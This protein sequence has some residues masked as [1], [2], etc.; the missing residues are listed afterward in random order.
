MAA[1]FD[2]FIIHKDALY[3]AQAAQAAFNV[4]DCIEA[5]LSKFIEN[6]DIARINSL[7]KGRPLQIGLSTF[8]CLQICLEMSKQTKG[9][10]DI[11]YGYSHKGGDLLKLNE[12][13][14]TIE[15]LEDGIQIDLGAIGKG[16]AADKIGQLLGDWGIN[17]AL[18]SAGQST[19]LP[20]G[21][22]PDLPGWPLS[23]SNPAD[24]RRLL[25][26]VHLADFA[27]SASGLQKGPHI[28]NPRSGK[29]VRGKLAAWSTAKTA[30][31]ADALST[32]FM[33]MPVNKIRDFCKAHPDTSA[34]LI[35]SGRK[36]EPVRFGQWKNT[37]FNY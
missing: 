30:A 17:T 9:A 33:V 16:Y 32:A 7:G 37:E 5:N 31:A 18:I 10:F 19:I 29:P 15:L 11:T 34:L 26:K 12:S 25:A 22:P 24:Y 21:T 2:I 6:S 3:A 14:H 36:K 20:I 28:I 35:P 13:D 8:E 4:T 23:L 27:V 1:T